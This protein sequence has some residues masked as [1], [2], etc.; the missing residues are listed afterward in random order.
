MSSEKKREKCGQGPGQTEGLRFPPARASGGGG[1]P[2]AGR[3]CAPSPA[4]ARRSFPAG[5][6]DPASEEFATAPSPPTLDPTARTAR[7]GRK[8]TAFLPL[9]CFFPPRRQEERVFQMERGGGWPTVPEANPR[10]QHARISRRG[11]INSYLRG[12]GSR[13]ELAGRECAC[14]RARAPLAPGLPI[15][16]HRRFSTEPPPPAAAATGSARSRPR[17]APARA[18]LIERGAH[19]SA[20]RLPVP[21]RL[22]APAG[23]GS[24]IAARG[25]GRGRC[26]RRLAAPGL[27]KQS[28]ISFRGP[29]PGSQAPRGRERGS[30][31]RPDGPAGSPR[32]AGGA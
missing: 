23:S 11:G 21:G 6:L 18:P 5:E 26:R 22:P 28:A 1:P 24:A 4:S 8:R 12:P 29:G 2:G 27:G 13:R 25:P 7:L 20:S 15:Q 31:R 10:A 16:C 30:G 32:S 14:V 17:P 19:Q 3:G 9:I